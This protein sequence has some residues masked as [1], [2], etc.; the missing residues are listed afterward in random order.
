MTKYFLP[1]PLF[2]LV[3]STITW[4]QQRTLGMLAIPSSLANGKE[5]RAYT[6]ARFYTMG[7]EPMVGDAA[8]EP[9][10]WDGFEDKIRIW[11]KLS[12]SFNRS[13]KF[14]IYKQGGR[15]VQKTITGTPDPDVQMSAL[16]V[17]IPVSY[18][19]TALK[20][21][22]FHFGFDKLGNLK[23]ETDLFIPA[24]LLKNY[25]KV[26]T[27]NKIAGGGKEDIATIFNG[28]SFGN[29]TVT[30]FEYFKFGERLTTETTTLTE[31]EVAARKKADAD[32][33]KADDD[34]RKADDEEKKK[35]LAADEAAKKKAAD[36]A[37]AKDKTTGAKTGSG[38]GG[39]SA[40]LTVTGSS[41][42]GASSG[43][44]SSAGGRTGG[45]TA[46]STPEFGKGPDGNYYRKGADGKYKQI[47]TEE[48][49][50]LKQ[51]KA[52]ASGGG[53]TSGGLTKQQQDAQLLANTQQKLQS[54]TDDFYA[55]QAESQRKAEQFSA[56]LAQS[57][58]AAEAIRSGKANLANASSLTGN[59]S[60][61]E[62]L[63]AEF[64]QKYASISGE[65]ENIANARNQQL[66]ATYNAFYSDAS[67][68]DK[69]IGQAATQIGSYINNM[70]AEKEEQRAK[71]E[72]R[73]QR[74]EQRARIEARRKEAM[75]QLRKG[76]FNEFP[77][78]G[79][80]LSGHKVVTNEL[81]FFSYVFDK[82]KID[83][84]PASVKVSNVF[85]IARY[86]DGT[87]PFKNNVVADVK[88]AA[89]GEGPVTLVGYYTT[90]EMA[91]NM[92]TS[93]LNLAS[94]CQITA[95][96]IAYKGKK[97]SGGT[98]TDFWGNAPKKTKAAGDSTAT[99]EPVKKKADDD[100]WQTGAVKKAAADT[101]RKAVKKDD[102]WNN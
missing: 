63:E 24:S 61:V 42:G 50:Q 13:T 47:S 3:F 100:F 28:L 44:G 40:G 17:Q 12:L 25:D 68:S 62:E 51:Q 35:K 60:S 82:T 43:G 55:R 54:M 102:F 70:R 59:Y 38:G 26:G 56:N 71:E 75:I 64:A 57:F 98:A 94:R 37:A 14:T 85:P 88:K 72:L 53:S 21:L 89:A 78:G 45:T 90:K 18:K 41:S 52:G 31:A 27:A 10:S 67:A 34:K 23:T 16:S 93:F 79:V 65:V 30:H 49:Q 91:D 80:P 33:K 19:G 39:S 76:F 48:Y 66:Q 81:Y 1:I 99:A 101:T 86:G 95:K 32:K 83:A 15:E 22:T 97:S 87:W 29:I 5:V 96:D 46:T 11:L 9:G 58:Y 2:V 84:G 92:R 74:E 8:M 69:A 73:R 36:E 20:T 6:G 7:Y 77:D 4:S